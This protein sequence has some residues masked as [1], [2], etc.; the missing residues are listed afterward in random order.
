[1]YIPNDVWIYIKSFMFKTLEMKKFDIFIKDLDYKMN[2]I[3]NI[4]FHNE[5]YEQM[6]YNSWSFSEKYMFL[7][8]YLAPQ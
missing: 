1:M 6:L 8:N 3:N 4:K 2:V 5:P 7:R